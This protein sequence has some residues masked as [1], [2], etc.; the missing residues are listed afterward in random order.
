MKV[1]VGKATNKTPQLNSSVNQI[2]FCPYWNVPNSILTK[3]ILPLIKRY[4]NYLSTF[5]ME[6][7]DGKLRQLPGRSN[8]LGLIKFVFPNPYDVYMHDTPLKNLFKENDRAFSHGCIR[9]EQP[10]KMALYLLKDNASWNESI[11]DSAVNKNKEQ[12]VKINKP[13]PIMIK[14]FTAWVDENQ[15]LQLRK[16]IYNLDKKSN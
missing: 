7:K 11:I 2:V 4:P 13:M 15:S 3:E 8:A 14:Y 5:S 12:W 10:K 6:W 16:D 9:M 1:I